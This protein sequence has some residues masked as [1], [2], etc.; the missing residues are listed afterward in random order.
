MIESAQ[1]SVI[2]C[3]EAARGEWEQVCRTCG[4]ATF[5]HTPLW[6][7]IFFRASDGRIVPAAEKV[8][9][10]DG[11][12]AV[13]PLVYRKHLSGLLRVYWSMPAGTFG[14]WVSADALTETHAAALI[15]RLGRFRDLVWRE[16]P[17]DPLL[18]NIAVPYAAED[19]TQAIDLRAGYGEA[20]KRSD[21][22]HRRAIQRAREAG[23]SVVEASK[24]EQWMTYFS[25][26]EKSRKRWK[27]KG[28][29]RSRGYSADLFKAIFESPAEHR[30]LWLALVKGEAV[31]GTIS[32]YWNRYAFS[33]NS[34]GDAAYFKEY[35]PND[36]LQDHI[37]RDA[38]SA[39]C[40]W[41]DCNPSAGLNGVVE[42]KE[43]I[44]AQK[45]RSRIISRRSFLRRTAE[46]ARGFAQ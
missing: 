43:H 39:G 7:D 36:L 10:S 15:A 27:A 21:Y 5:F 44:G 35:R 6:A 9:F 17:Y 37:I 11:A 38:A 45:K 19:F 13:V 2:A 31:Y 4:Y 46:L 20:R 40:E 22:A 26:S 33:W 1:V 8:A 16:N 42:F 34:A 30:K 28:L 41:Y 29:L 3:H 25:L 14:G 12:T 23:V 24:F 18:R 32:F